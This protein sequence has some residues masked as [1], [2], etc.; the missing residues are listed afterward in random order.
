MGF[1]VIDVSIN[2]KVIKKTRI[3]GPFSNVEGIVSDIDINQ[4]ILT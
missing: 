1:L 3:F 4:K 2:R